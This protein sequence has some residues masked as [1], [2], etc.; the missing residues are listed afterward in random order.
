[1]HKLRDVRFPL[2]TLT[3]VVIF[4]LGHMILLYALRHVTI[5][6]AAVSGVVVSGVLLL[7]IA[8]H[9]GLVAAL[10]RP[11]YSFFRRRSRN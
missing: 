4:V 9:L 5:S 3:A 1:M 7:M 8:K 6:H 10:L 11:V 2:G